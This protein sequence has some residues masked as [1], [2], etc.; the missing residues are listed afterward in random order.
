ME[1]FAAIRRDH[2]M[3]GLS[4]RALADKHHVHRRTVRQALESSIPPARKTPQRIAPRLEPFKTAID[5]MLRSDVE[6]PKKQRHT[7]RRILARLVDEHGAVGLSYSTVRD[8]VRQRRPQIL[9][10]AGKPL[11]LGYVPQTHPPAAEAEVDF[12]DLW[13]MLRG[14]KTKT[15][16][17]TMRLSYSGR[18]AHRAFLTQGQE[19]FLE[20]HVYALQRL[21]GVPCDK[22]RYDNLN[23]AVKQVLFGRSRQENERWI[24]FRSHYGFEAWYCQ[25]GHEGSHEKGGVE[26]EGGRFRRNHCVPMPV[27]DSIDELNA[28]LEAADDADDKRRIANRANSVGHD[29]SFEKTLLRMLPGDP[30]DTALTVTP[31]VDRYAQVM[32]RCNQYSVPARFIGH[33]LR[34]K[35][36]ASAV[37]VYDRN[38]V[39]ARHQRAVGKGA[40]VL[41]LDHYLEILLRKPGALPGA[42]ALAQARASKVFTAEHEAFWVAARKAHGDAVGTRALVEVLLLH[43]HLDRVDMLAGITAALSVG[44]TSSDVVALEARKAAERRGAAAGAD[45]AVGPGGRV[46]ILAEHRSATVPVDERPLPSVDQYD[47]LLGRETS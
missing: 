6:A 32:V 25:P 1:Q 12:H 36:S 20:G 47:T 44:S 35:L 34:V 29:W 40:K 11:E 24:A 33:R 41:D 2:R 42:T 3:D 7:A 17:F 16:L 45:D 27:V 39:V 37:I 18:A 19:A 13:V 9:A 23:S 43:R 46:V 31:R 4:I 21:G 15:A 22:V 14:V 8:H 5:E 28:L 38:T 26:G 30:F 10:E